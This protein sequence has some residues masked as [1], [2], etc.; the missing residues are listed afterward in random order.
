M[1]QGALWLASLDLIETETSCIKLGTGDGRLQLILMRLDH[2]RSY[3]S[4]KIGL[5]L[6]VTVILSKTIDK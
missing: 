2:S 6:R 3:G 4:V 1:V 5:L